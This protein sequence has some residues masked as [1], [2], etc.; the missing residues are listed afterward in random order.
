MRDV[1]PLGVGGRFL[2][3]S[4]CGGYSAQPT[5][6]IYN[7]AKFGKSNKHVTF[8]IVVSNTLSSLLALE[9]FTE[10]LSKEMDPSWNISATIIQP[11]GFRT[12]WGGSSLKTYPPP[13]Q[14]ADP[15]SPCA[16]FRVMA[17]QSSASA[18]GD[19][20][21][22]AQAML[23]VADMPTVPLRIQ[24]GTESMAIVVGK[25]KE[26]LTNAEKYADIAHS[27]NAEGV[28]T[29]AILQMLSV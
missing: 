6:A 20:A 8:S 4:S 13:P 26:T 11:G 18:I 7:A 24:L 21:K 17:F 12:E 5:I 23:A 28:D 29:K 10:S 15:G 22:A 2:N 9:G 14:Y 19:P 16:K 1:N 27:T 25:A 3:I